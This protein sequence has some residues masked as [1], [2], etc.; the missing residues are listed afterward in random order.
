MQKK[1]SDQKEQV[2]FKIQ[3]LW[4]HNLVEK[5]LRYTCFPNQLTGFY[6]RGV[7]FV[8]GLIEYNQRHIG[9]LRYV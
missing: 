4:R 2:D 6:M 7:F 1:W 5:C 9:Q 3:N 8:K